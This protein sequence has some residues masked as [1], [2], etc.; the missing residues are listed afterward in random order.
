MRP[1]IAAVKLKDT[2]SIDYKTVPVVHTVHPGLG[3]SQR[4]V[5][6][7]PVKFPKLAAKFNCLHEGNGQ[8]DREATVM[9]GISGN[10]IT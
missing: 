10:V 6:F 9:R 4:E 7:D 2:K 5:Y 1:P 8:G 3:R